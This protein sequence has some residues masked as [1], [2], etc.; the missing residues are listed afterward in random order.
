MGTGTPCSAAHLAVVR[1]VV[2]GLEIGAQGQH[3]ALGAQVF[4][5]LLHHGQQVQEVLGHVVVLLEEQHQS[6]GH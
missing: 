5:A 6:C 1:V 2:E 4:G 3:V